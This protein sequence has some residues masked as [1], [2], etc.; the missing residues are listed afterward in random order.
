ME[1]GITVASAW[2]SYI[3]ASEIL[4]NVEDK[5]LTP[6]HILPSPEVASNLATGLIF[7]S[8]HTLT[9]IQDARK[10]VK[11]PGFFPGWVLKPPM[12]STGT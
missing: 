1:D 8:F 5:E 6:D 7:C 10:R 3:F 11:L 12:D 9:S 2:V 4:D